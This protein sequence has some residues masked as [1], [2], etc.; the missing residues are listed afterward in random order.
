MKIYAVM[1]TNFNKIDYRVVYM[2][3]WEGDAESLREQLADW[4]CC[5]VSD[6]ATLMIRPATVEE[7]EWYNSD[8]YIE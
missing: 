3:E 7:I 2:R 1:E 6:L 5:D 8:A 4:G